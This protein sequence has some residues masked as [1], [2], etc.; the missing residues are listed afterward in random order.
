MNK[1]LL[2]ILVVCLMSA[3]CH[4]ND[5]NPPDPGTTVLPCKLV[6][7]NFL[8]FGISLNTFYLYADDGKLFRIAENFT[9]SDSTFTTYYYKG[10][11]FYY[12]ARNNDTTFYFYNDKGLLSSTTD[13]YGNIR[14]FFY[15]D[16]HQ[17]IMS[18][19]KVVIRSGTSIYDSTLYIWSEDNVITMIKYLNQVSKNWASLTRNYTYDNKINYLK[20]TGEPGIFPEYWSKNN[21]IQMTT[22]GHPEQTYIIDSLEYNSNGFPT[23]FH[24]SPPDTIFPDYTMILNYQCK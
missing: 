5:S 7:S 15:N 6:S 19:I 9:G 4:K 22:V 16:Y 13:N 8:M 17:V 24:A 20:A 3:G 11:K 14:E 21:I 10:D 18:K 23:K 12:S 1:N 2:L